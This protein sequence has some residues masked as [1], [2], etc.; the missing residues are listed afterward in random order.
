MALHVAL[1]HRTEY[2]YDRPDRPRPAD[3]AA[4]PRAALAHADP[5]LLA[6]HHAERPLHQLAAGSVRQLPGAAGVSR[7]DARVQGEVD[8]VADMATINPFDFFVDEYAR[9]WPF[10]YEPELKEELTPYLKAVGAGAAAARTIS[11][12][13]SIEAKTSID[14]IWALNRQLQH[15]IGYLIRMEPGVQ[16][17][18]E[19]L[20]KRSGSCRD[21]GWLLVHILRHSGSRRASCR[22]T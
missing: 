2:T 15:D 20:K 21:S 1:T 9:D 17:P 3:R 4:A 18:E 14:F 6:E 19:T 10:K 22:A 11:G 13:S 8:L 16:T 5:V 12:A 7:E